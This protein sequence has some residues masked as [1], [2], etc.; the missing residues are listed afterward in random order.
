SFGPGSSPATTTGAAGTSFTSATCACGGAG[1]A[2][3]GGASK[4]SGAACLG[5]GASAPFPVSTGSKPSSAAP[6]PLGSGGSSV[7]ACSTPEPS[8]PTTA[9]G[10]GPAG[11]GGRGSDVSLA[12]SGTL[13]VIGHLRGSADAAL[14]RTAGWRSPDRKV[15]RA[16]WRQSVR[17][18]AP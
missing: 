14:S 4:P 15:P 10:V 5:N 16:G 7:A 3:A 9:E 13:Y 18:R 12:G 11:S 6:S 1:G 8:G 2:S 17:P